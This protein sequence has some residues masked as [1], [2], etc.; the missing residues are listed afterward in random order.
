MWYNTSRCYDSYTMYMRLQDLVCVIINSEC[1][2]CNKMS[3]KKTT[4]S[5]WISPSLDLKS[6]HHKSLKT[7]VLA[8]LK[9]TLQTE[10]AHHTLLPLL[11]KT[12]YNAEMCSIFQCIWISY[13][14]LHRL[15]NARLLLDR[16]KTNH[17]ESICQ[18]CF[19]YLTW[20][21]CGHQ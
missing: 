4:K 8:F 11:I 1:F 19:H 10:S 2:A 16:R 14:L 12:Q 9:A 21:S 6:F 20:L 15:K 7:K 3:Y 17:C 18:E 13:S 5:F